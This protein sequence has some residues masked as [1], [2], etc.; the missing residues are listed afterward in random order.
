VM[1]I[2][3]FYLLTGVGGIRLPYSF[4]REVV[5][6][7]NLVGIKI[8]PFE[9]YGTLDVVRA[10]ADARRENSITLYTGND[11]S[12]VYDL[13][14]PYRFGPPDT[15]PAVRIR[16]GL[17]GQWACWTRR[18]VEFHERLLRIGEG[19]EGITPEL[20]T[21]SAQVTD[22]NAAVFDAA[23][24]FAGSIPGV[25]EILRRQGLFEGNWTLKRDEG[26]SPGQAEEI[27]RVCAAYPHLADD[28]FVRA[29]LDGWLSG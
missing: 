12:I 4:W 28:D 17:L 29:N 10:V 20:L 3:G 16:G 8:A 14:T 11:D 6:I 27:D 19:V 13:V 1:P 26:L 24:G 23:H 22:A 25:N 2:F 18:A 21:L 15:A 7:E 5:E 9:R